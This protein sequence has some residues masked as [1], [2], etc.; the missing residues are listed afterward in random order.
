MG[1][2]IVYLVSIAV[3]DI[4]ATQVG[5][6]TALEE[7]RWQSQAALSVAWAIVGMIAFV[8]G[9][10]LERAELRIGGLVLL[11]LTT[12]KVFAIDLAALDVAYKVLALFGLG[13]VLVVSG[14]LWQRLHVRPPRAPQGPAA[15]HR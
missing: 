14:G 5:G 1:V 3:V 6:A 7:L 10:R 2:E 9:L 8:A 4:F 15:V 12:V 11:G 13:L